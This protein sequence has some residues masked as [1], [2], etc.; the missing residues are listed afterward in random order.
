MVR[1][2]AAGAGTPVYALKGF[3]RFHRLSYIPPMR[4]TL[5]VALALFV[6]L[7]A[8]ASVKSEVYRQ[9]TRLAAIL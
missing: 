8:I 1:A 6:A 7:P 5:L 3:P 2:A 4:K 9:G